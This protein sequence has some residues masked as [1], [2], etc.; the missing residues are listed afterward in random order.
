MCCRT[1]IPYIVRMIEQARRLSI[2]P[3]TGTRGVGVVFGLVLAGFGAAFAVAAWTLAR[4]K[5]VDLC[6]PAPGLPHQPVDCSPQPSLFAYHDPAQW[7]AL[8]GV[9]FVLAGVV[10]AVSALR[11]GVWL[12]GTTLVARGMRTRTVDLSTAAVTM[13]MRPDVAP[14]PGLDRIIELTA[15]ATSGVAVRLSWRTELVPGAELRQLAA[16][17][18]EGRP[19]GG[20]GTEVAARLRAVADEPRSGAESVAEGLGG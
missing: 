9:P 19:A 8:V 1:D 7:I 18:T 6:A 16:A 15:R 11:S 13:T 20:T 4:P 12:D 2:R 10:L 3:P 5:Y 17:I 14:R